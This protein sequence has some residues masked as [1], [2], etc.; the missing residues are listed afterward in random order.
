MT[1]ELLDK[2]DKIIIRS[3]LN[4]KEMVEV[5]DQLALSVPMHIKEEH[6]IYTKC[7]KCKKHLSV[8]HGDG[9]YSCEKYKFCPECRQVFNWTS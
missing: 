1:K 8:H 9:Y 2:M 5:Y 7:P 3:D 6:Y 4:A